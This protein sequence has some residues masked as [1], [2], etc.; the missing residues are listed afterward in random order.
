MI[1]R[2]S[3]LGAFS[4]LRGTLVNRG[5]QGWQICTTSSCIQS[6]GLLMTTT[7]ASSSS[8]TVT[9]VNMLLLSS[10][11]RDGSHWVHPCACKTR[12]F[13]IR[14]ALVMGMDRAGFWLLSEMT[15]LHLP[16]WGLSAALDHCLRWSSS[17]FFISSVTTAS[18]F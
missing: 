4:V 9:Y 7:L 3:F 11:A 15:R 2:V 16:I 1:G 10:T 12:E 8:F 14:F 13:G 6:E 18:L 5:M 17:G